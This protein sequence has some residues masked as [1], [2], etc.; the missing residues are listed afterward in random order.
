MASSSAD[1]IRI[2]SRYSAALF[3]L[4]SEKKQL[5][6][7]RRD[8]DGVAQLLEAS[9][10]FNRLIE[11]PVATREEQARA[12]DA[13]LSALGAA[14]LT[15]D[16]FRTLAENRRLAVTPWIIRH[17]HEKLMESR[18]ETSA[19]VVSAYALSA[20]QILALKAALKKA[21]GRR[22]V[23]VEAT[24]DPQILGGVVVKVDGK[25]F[26]NSIATK[27]NLLAGSMKSGVQA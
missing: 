14:K 11:S 10:G 25:M 6:A 23:H 5:D 12:V 13:V 27:I 2:A 16:F 8:L 7:V 18:N 24:E 9:T 1:R 26:D 21:T 19:Q 20:D 3:D 22:E 15:R 4:A 17:Y